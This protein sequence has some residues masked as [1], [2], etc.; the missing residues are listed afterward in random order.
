VRS[1]IPQPHKGIPRLAPKASVQTCAASY[2]FGFQ[3]QEKDNEIHDVD[4]S[5]LA[6]EY[7]MHDP[8]I[9]R[10]LSIDPLA[11]KYPFYSPYAF[12]GNRVIDCVE[13]EGLE[14]SGV[15]PTTGVNTT[16]NDTYSEHGQ[17]DTQLIYPTGGPTE[18]VPSNNAIDR[19]LRW[20]GNDANLRGNAPDNYNRVEGKW[21]GFMYFAPEG[22]SGSPL[23]TTK[24]FWVTMQDGSY[25]P[26]SILIGMSAEAPGVPKGKDFDDWDDAF[27]VDGSKLFKEIAGGTSSSA[28]GFTSDAA[29]KAVAPVLERFTSTEA[30]QQAERMVVHINAD[31]S[32]V[33]PYA[34]P[35]TA[36]NR[37]AANKDGFKWMKDFQGPFSTP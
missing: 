19:G 2:S 28:D 3:G 29:K 27:D 16:A 26:G 20:L 18:P 34:V 31:S 7:R 25:Q 8:R 1:A 17:W 37:K 11:S 9:G 22:G 10:F 5:M 32:T 14:P 21:G 13:L 33:V 4:G 6:F 30:K 35:N 23:K 15:N 36:H 24:P 12:S